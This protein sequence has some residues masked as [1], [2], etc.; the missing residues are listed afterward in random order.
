MDI[1]GYFRLN[2]HRILMVI[3]GYFRLNY[4]RPLVPILLVAIVGYSIIGQW[5]FIL[6]VAILGYFILSH[7]ILF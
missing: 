1:G 3:G 4:H 7:Y 2:Y 6:L 5:W